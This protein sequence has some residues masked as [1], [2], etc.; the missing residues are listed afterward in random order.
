[1]PPP[2]VAQDHPGDGTD[3]QWTG[4]GAG[5][6]MMMNAM[7]SEMNLV[8]TLLDLCK[9]LLI[10]N[11]KLRASLESSREFEQYQSVEA[12]L[13]TVPPSLTDEKKIRDAFDAF[14]EQL[15]QQRDP[16]TLSRELLTMLE[17]LR[18]S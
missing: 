16:A 7:T 15:Q 3:H 14:H 18:R 17:R 10:E 5:G 13:Q 12:L 4:G 1:L 9:N 11:L 8:L 2:P 6:D